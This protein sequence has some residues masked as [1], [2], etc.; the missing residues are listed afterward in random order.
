MKNMCFSYVYMHENHGEKHMFLICFFI[1]FSYVSIHMFSYV[2]N[3]MFP[4][5]CTKHMFHYEKHTETYVA[6]FPV[7]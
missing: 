5:A 4:L 1:C 7:Y 3:H 2:Q 6:I